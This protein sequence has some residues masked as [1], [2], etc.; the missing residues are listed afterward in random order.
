M[1]RFALLN[2]H[3]ACS[4]PEKSWEDYLPFSIG[5]NKADLSMKDLLAHQAGL[6]PFMLFWKETMKTDTTYK[7]RFISHEFSSKHPL[8][9]ADN[10]YIN[11]KFKKRMF[12]EIRKSL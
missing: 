3:G 6:V 5:S 4:P 9:V 2:K 1:A 12:A 7:R 11:D 8:K 10:L